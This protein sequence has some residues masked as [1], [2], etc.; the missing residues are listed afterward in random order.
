MKKLTKQ[1]QDEIFYKGKNE[2]K[3]FMLNFCPMRTAINVIGG[4]WKLLILSYLMTGPKRYGELF[5]LM[6]EISE[7]MLIQ[8]LRELEADLIIERK[9]YH[10]VPPKV[11]YFLTQHGHSMQPIIES[12]LEWGE[13]YK[14]R[15]E[16]QLVE[17]EVD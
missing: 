6:N 10:Q 15:A 13:S 4:K 8:E 16:R 2:N 14:N 5:R 7:K 1:Q 12:M 17:E 3:E 9:I 11:E